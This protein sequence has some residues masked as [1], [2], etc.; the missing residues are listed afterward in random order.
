MNQQLTIVLVH[1]AGTGP[2]I[3]RRVQE[4]LSL[5]SIAV[6]MPSRRPNATPLSCVEHIMKEIDQVCYVPEVVHEYK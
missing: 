6:E 5:P 2:W 4:S 1:G 3:W